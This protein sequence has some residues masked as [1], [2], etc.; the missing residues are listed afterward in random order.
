MHGT[1]GC[2][3][4]I[5]TLLHAI[6]IVDFF[7][8]ED[9]YLKT[10]DITHDHFG[11]M[12]A[13]GD[14]IF[15]PAFYTLQTQFLARRPTHAPTWQNLSILAL[16]LAGYAIFRSANHQ[17]HLA[18]ATDGACTLWRRPA[19]FLRCTYTTADGAAHDTILLT[20]GW[21]GVC[22]HA[23]YLADLL[24][25]WAM[26][27]TCGFTHLL[28]WSYFVYMLVLLTHR[29]WRDEARCRA[30]YGEKW[31]EYCRQVRWRLVPGVY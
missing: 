16:G 6:Y 7:L 12:L 24:Q 17:K 14:T 3:T 22:R 19:T 18:R 2:S 25:A 5:T 10:I 28:P 26:C 27:A 4:I 15:L 31:D 23:N 8:N 13:W 9:W 29:V 1:V 11:F 20:S 21:W 30:K